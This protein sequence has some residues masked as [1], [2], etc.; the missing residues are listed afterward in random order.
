MKFKEYPHGCPDFRVH[1]S[2]EEAIKNN[3]KDHFKPLKNLSYTHYV[4]DSVFDDNTCEK[5]INSDSDSPW[6]IDL[7]YKHMNE[8][9]D[10]AGWKYNITGHEEPQLQKY[11]VNNYYDWHRD[12]FGDHKSIWKEESIANDKLYKIGT[13]RKLTMTILLNDKKDFKGG[14]YKV[15]LPKNQKI[16]FRNKG[17]I[18]VT[19]AFI[20]HT[21]EPVTSG[22]RITLS[23]FFLGPPFV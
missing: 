12:G 18:V 20:A 5:I 4:I 15:F 16:S 6:L 1:L 17:S 10:V 21:V 19:P 13:T 23:T 2:T 11:K 22:E 7:L 9:N 8:I 3:V 14:D